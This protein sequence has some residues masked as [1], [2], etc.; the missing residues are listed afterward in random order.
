RTQCR[1]AEKPAAGVEHRPA[2][3]AAG[4][5]DVERDAPVDASAGAAVPFWADR[6]NDAEAHRNA[7]FVGAEGQRERT[8]MRLRGG[9]RRQLRGAVGQGRGEV[10]SEVADGARAQAG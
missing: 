2:V 1:D 9:K 10:G 8:G 5:G 7:A 4:E 3:L 6:V